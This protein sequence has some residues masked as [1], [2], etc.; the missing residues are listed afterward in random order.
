MQQAAQ[1]L[2]R[3]AI[4]LARLFPEL[5]RSGGRVKSALLLASQMQ[6]S[7]QLQPEAY[8]LWLKADHSLSV[9]DEKCTALQLLMQDHANLDEVEAQFALW[10]I[11]PMGAV[12]E[13]AR[14]ALLNFAP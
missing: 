2:E 3:F 9:A 7:L 4:L 14:E 1:R 12:P 11:A 8:R 5:E 6:Q 10:A 13:Q